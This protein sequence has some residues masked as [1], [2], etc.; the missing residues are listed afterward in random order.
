MTYFLEKHFEVD[1]EG[2][3]I[4]PYTGYGMCLIRPCKWSYEKILK[5]MHGKLSDSS[6]CLEG[7]IAIFNSKSPSTFM[8][9]RK[10]FNNIEEWLIWLEL[11]KN[12]QPD[13]EEIRLNDV[14]YSE[15][16]VKT[17]D[18]HTNEVMYDTTKDTIDYILDGQFNKIA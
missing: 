14:Y 5:W 11:E 10:T 6:L 3:L 16:V 4:Q 13:F 18:L 9:E 8:D 12:I 15:Y 2:N 1:S 7:S 17:I